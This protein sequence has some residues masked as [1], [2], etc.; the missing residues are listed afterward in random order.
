LVLAN[1]GIFHI[2]IAG[3]WAFIQQKITHMG[4][5]SA[6]GGNLLAL[7]M[8]SGLAGALYVAFRQTSRSILLW[9]C[10]LLSIAAPIGVLSGDITTVTVAGIVLM[11]A[12]NVSVPHQIALLGHDMNAKYYLVFVPGFQGVGLAGGPVLAGL[13]TQPG[14]YTNLAAVAF[15]TFLLSAFMFNLSIRSVKT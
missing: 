13:I 11:L 1:M 8:C 15:L 12:W 6:T 2:G 3:V 5:A 9:T 14:E 10:I 7:M 4:L